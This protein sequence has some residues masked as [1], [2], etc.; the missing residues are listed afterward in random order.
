MER[1]KEELEI[2]KDLLRTYRISVAR[3]LRQIEETEQRIERLEA[4]IARR[5]AQRQHR[6]SYSRRESNQRNSTPSKD[7]YGQAINIG[8]EVKILT[9]G[10]F[11][12]TEGIVTKDQARVTVRSHSRRR[13][14]HRASH[15]LKVLQDDG[16]SDKCVGSDDDHDDSTRKQSNPPKRK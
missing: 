14:T 1:L 12:F 9:A 7:R 2:E 11:D 15:N 4:A 8:D 13:S 16:E 3:K 5:A 10:K 6:E